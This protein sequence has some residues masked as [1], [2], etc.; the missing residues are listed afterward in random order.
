MLKATK[1][2]QNTKSRSETS[3]KD[4]EK[5][6]MKVIAEQDQ[7]LQSKYHRTKILQIEAQSEG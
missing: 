3:V 5:L 1:N 2:Q 6:K 4:V 7:A